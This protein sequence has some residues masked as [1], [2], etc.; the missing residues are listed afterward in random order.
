[1]KNFVVKLLG[2]YFIWLC[3]NMSQEAINLLVLPY[4]WHLDFCNDTHWR[5]PWSRLN[6]WVSLQNSVSNSAI[7]ILDFYPGKCQ[8]LR[9]HLHFWDYC[10]NCRLWTQFLIGFKYWATQFVIKFLFNLIL[11]LAMTI[12]EQLALTNERAGSVTSDQPRARKLEISVISKCETMDHDKFI[13]EM[14]CFCLR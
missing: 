10:P 1:M 11:V 8:D 2:N 13:C 7:T 5:H 6:I 3:L 4:W 12:I 14:A 9:I